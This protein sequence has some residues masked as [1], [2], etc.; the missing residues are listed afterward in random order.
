MSGI[1]LNIGTMMTRSERTQETFIAPMLGRLY[2]KLP[3]RIPMHRLFSDCTS[4]KLQVTSY[5]WYAKLIL[6][7]TVKVPKLSGL[8]FRVNSENTELSTKY[9]GCAMCA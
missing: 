9:C 3:Q 6:V 5:I 1:L 2:S 7:D 4:V 8:F